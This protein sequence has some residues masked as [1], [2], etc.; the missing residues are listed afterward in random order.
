MQSAQAGKNRESENAINFAIAVAK[1]CGEHEIFIALSE[2][3]PKSLE[4]IR[5]K[6]RGILPAENIRVWSAPGSIRLDNPN[7]IVWN[8]VAEIIREG[9]LGA[10][11]PDLVHLCSVTQGYEEDVISGVV[12]NNGV[13]NISVMLLEG[14][15]FYTSI[16]NNKDQNYSRYLKN[17]LS[18][19]RSNSLVF[20]DSEIT[21]HYL[22]KNFDIPSSNIIELKGSE[23]SDWNE[24]AIKTISS[25]ELW[26]D[27]NKIKKQNI[28]F[29]QKKKMAYVSPMPPIK[30][31]IADYSAELIIHLSEYYEIQV[32]DCTIMDEVC[33]SHDYKSIEWLRENSDGFDRIIYHFGNSP[34]HH[35]LVKLIED[36]PGIAVMHD[37]YLG[38]LLQYI[39]GTGE[40]ENAWRRALY[41]AHGYRAVKASYLSKEYE[42]LAFEYP[43]N[44]NIV[45]NATGI[46][47][48]SEYAKSLAKKFYG[49]NISKDWH[50]IPLIRKP[51]QKIEK[52][53]ARKLLGIDSGVFLVAS[54]G[55]LGLLKQNKKLIEAWNASSLSQSAN[56]KLVF[57]GEN[58][59]DEYGL[60]LKKAIIDNHL[61]DQIRMTGYVSTEEYELYLSAADLAV[62]LRTL[63]R[64]ETSAAVYDCL[65]YGL[66][67]I[68]NA[69]GS[70]RELNKEYV[71]I[72][73]DNFA[74]LELVRALEAHWGDVDSKFRTGTCSIEL[75]TKNNSGKKCAQLY[76][77]SIE[78]SYEDKSVTTLETARKVVEYTRHSFEDSEL[79][80]I[81][82]HIAK[83]L[84]TTKR[85][86][87]IF[88]DVTVTYGN[89][90][91]TGIQRVVR[92]LLLALIESPP[93]GYRIEPVYITSNGGSWH[94][95]HAHKYT[96]EMLGCGV[97]GFSDDPVDVG[98]GDIMLLLDFS[99]GFIVEP[100]SSQG[101]FSNYRNFGVKVWTF[102]YD[103]LPI[104]LP[105]SF[106]PFMQGYHQRWLEIISSFDGAICISK[107][108]SEEYID[109]RDRN[110]FHEIDK[111]PFI[112]KWLHLGADIASSSPS[113][114]LPENASNVLKKLT[115]SI[116][117]LMVGTVEPRK[118]HLQVLEAFNILWEKGEDIS[119]C[120]VGKRGWNDSIGV[121]EKTSIQLTKNK[122]VG[123]RL[124]WIEHASDEYL[125]RIYSSSECLICASYGEG[126]GLPLIEGANHG[127]SIIARDIPVFHEVAGDGAYYFSAKTSEEL[128]SQLSEWISLYGNGVAPKS[129]DIKHITWRE[130]GDLLGSYLTN[131]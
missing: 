27:I 131:Y 113:I 49:E 11:N 87:S 43:V 57:V 119:L 6:F 23:V 53:I 75:L 61:A 10:L 41:D 123:K 42:K 86:K 98:L 26:V 15:D 16:E 17:N 82:S 85:Q 126:F 104:S 64:G 99:S 109:W 5:E 48:H 35:G 51:A 36:I 115:S 20:V 122:Q 66:P 106:P 81:S 9:F 46:V 129:S 47:V 40:I 76:F 114:G 130:C 107:A 25:W 112:T 125:E 19:L 93:D 37:F 32:I 31:G 1:N 101:L 84:M 68:V 59:K 8:R 116:T 83:S 95:R 33:N 58:S 67:L 14:A 73:S 78:K 79:V 2:Y 28:N 108:V 110:G 29:L 105:S 102:I 4:N 89:D 124:F 97:D 96:L 44:F 30:S 92:A 128:A 60:E 52:N 7:N 54:F 118:G 21:S 65:S 90:Y 34:Y 69:N 120:I 111:L 74:E 50:V 18:K 121:M 72:I 3:F 88:V 94:I 12:D 77:E 24:A 39:E 38:H 117:F 100:E 55:H 127:I 62:Q 91:K 13:N 103:L 71:S 45:K 80:R 56:C 63:S 70:M 22:R